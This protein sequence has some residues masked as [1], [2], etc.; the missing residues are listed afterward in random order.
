M[1]SV[2]LALTVY[3]IHDAYLY[4]RHLPAILACAFVVY[5]ACSF[6]ELPFQLL[7]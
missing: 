2:R 7:R 5:L 6:F 3:F 1:S 4:L